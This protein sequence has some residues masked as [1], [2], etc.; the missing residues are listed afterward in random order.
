M[1]GA[2]SIPDHAHLMIAGLISLHAQREPHRLAIKHG[3][4]HLTY[5]LVDEQLRRLQAGLLTARVIDYKLVGVAHSDPLVESLLLFAL[6][7]LGV[8][9]LPFIQPT[10]VSIVTALRD[11]DLLVCEQPIE[12]LSVPYALITNE[13]LKAVVNHPVLPALTMRQKPVAETVNVFTTSGSMG[14]AKAIVFGAG[15][16]EARIAARRTQYGLERDSRLL[17]AMPPSTSGT[18]FAAQA[19]LRVGGTLVYFDQ[20][21]AVADLAQCTHAMM[22][23]GLLHRL[24]SAARA[25]PRPIRCIKIFATGAKLDASTRQL[26]EETLNAELIDAYGTT[27]TGWLAMFRGSTIGDVLPGVELEVVD[28]QD[29]PVP[30][31]EIGQ[32]R[33]RSPEM[34]SGYLDQLLSSQV[35]RGGWYYTG[36]FARMPAARRIELL[37]REDA[38]MNFG[39][40]KIAPEA[41]EA[42]LTTRSLAADV[43]VLSLLTSEGREQLVVACVAPRFEGTALDLELVRAIGPNL[44]IIKVVVLDQVPRNAAGKLLRDE[45]R[46]RV[47][48]QL[49]RP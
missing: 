44:G 42:A 32:I 28:Q 6:E 23:P 4:R 18:Y 5:R 8:A 36:D 7:A 3:E 22:L 48:E 16:L 14:A 39:G 27:E 26:A 24:A 34:G 45:L 29:Q 33:V 47:E 11:C 40:I 15:A 12:G 25:Q 10:D 9:T 1:S 19:L 31:G 41:V 35:F 13:W 37:G 2:P 20:A 21:T 38:M 49:F 30:Y 43:A 17:V 46:A